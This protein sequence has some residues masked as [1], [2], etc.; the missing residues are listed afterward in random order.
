[1]PAPRMEL[2]AELAPHLDPPSFSFDDLRLLPPER[3]LILERRHGS[4]K[5]HR[6]NIRL[7][8]LEMREGRERLRSFPW[9]VQLNLTSRCN[10][11][12]TFC[13]VRPARKIRDDISL[14]DVRRMDWLRHVTTFAVWG[15]IG[16]SLAHPEFAPIV[17]HL[18]TAF[19][20]LKLEL[21]TNGIL[22]NEEICRLLAD[23]FSRVNVSINAATRETWERILRARGF[24]HVCAMC[25]RLAE[26]RPSRNAP[27]LTFSMVMSRENIHEAA[28]FVKLA[29]DLGADQAILFHYWPFSLIGQREMPAS[30]SLY[31][32]RERCDAELKR[33]AEMAD[34]LGLELQAPVPFADKARH[35]SFGERS[36]TPH[37]ACPYPW[38]SFFLTTDEAGHREA[39][40]CCSG[41]YPSISYDKGAL[42]EEGFLRVWNHP[43]AR[44]FRRTANTRGANAVCDWCA[45]ED[46]LVPDRCSLY[47]INAGLR[48]Y[49]E[50][51][52]RR[53]AAG[54]DV[55]VAE[56]CQEIGRLM[57]H[58]EGGR[59]RMP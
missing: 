3:D 5:A 20:H 44:W 40:F 55:S 14:E 13:A 45:G 16:E 10:A 42:D 57:P 24:D 35:I 32:D 6:L 28:A 56:M 59:P 47:G 1:M 31:H 8:E 46:R 9:H 30:Q 27:R 18:R 38:T 12:C 50:R 43:A 54:E 52:D 23:G 48:P 21:G 41:F 11:S 49:F 29:H 7:N 58:E 15:N 22:L 19:P 53:F 39:S 51:V 36:S 33:A 26:L 4:K 25:A 37:P 34:R 2:L 17:R